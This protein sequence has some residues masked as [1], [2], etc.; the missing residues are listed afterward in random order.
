VSKKYVRNYWTIALIFVAIS[1]LGGA[2]I[3]GAAGQD[4]PEPQR[5]PL[6]EEERRRAVQRLIEQLQKQQGVNPRLV[7]GQPAPAAPA[8]GQPAAP[9]A[10]PAPSPS[11]SPVPSVVQRAPL[12]GGQVQLSYDNADLYEFINQIA[13]T[14]GLTPV[15][16]DPEVKG[17]VTIHSSAPMAKEDL[18][19]LFNLILKNNNA[20]LVKQGNIYQIVPISS[21]LKKGLDII[22]H[23][24]PADA[25]PDPQTTGAVSPVAPTVP[26]TPA[27]AVPQPGAQVVLSQPASQQSNR[28]ATHV[29][30]VE[31]V[32]VRDLIDPLKLFMTEGGII[33][34][35]DRLNM[36]IV[37]DYGDS[38][39][40]I[41]DVIRLLDSN[42][43]DPELVELAKI[44]NNAS[45]DVAED[46]KKIFGSGARESA[47]GVNFVS[48]DRLNSILI[49][50]S[51]K[52]A[53]TEARTWIERLDATTGRSV[54]TY[55]YTVE[56]STAA[57]IAQILSALFGSE[58]GVAGFTGTSE[59]GAAGPFGV[60]RTPQSGSTQ[61]G[62][63]VSGAGGVTGGTAAG[64]G[65]PFGAGSAQGGYQ[66]SGMFGGGSTFGGGGTGGGGFGG[67]GGAFGGGFIGG[68]QQL[69]PRLNPTGSVSSQVLR[70]GGFSGLQDSVRVV[71]DE[72]NNALI[73]QASAPD[74]FYITDVI[75]KLDVLPRQALID[76]RIFEVDL[77]DTFAFGISGALRP[78]GSG[79]DGEHLTTAAIDTETGALSAN[80]FA[81]IGS[82]RDILLRLDALRT[83][84]KV[85]ILEAP[86]V[87]ALDG[88]VARIVV[89]AE[90][91]YP[92]T[93]FIA[94][95]GGS[96][97]SVQYRDTGISLI[98]E[99]RISGSGTVTLNV[100]Q[101]VSSPGAATPTG[102]TFTKTSVATTLAVQDG[103]TVAIAGLIRDANSH[104]RSGVPFLSEIP[105][106]GSLFGTTTKTGNRTELLILITP[107]VIRNPESFQHM[108][109]ELKDSLRNVRKW[110]D[111]KQEEHV[112]DMEDARKDRVKEE[113]KQMKKTGPRK[114]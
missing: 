47:T 109:Q 12:A 104:S 77:T 97:T 27:P 6:N 18:L 19:P 59:R 48:L 31:F 70:G 9:G 55:V 107:H 102:P 45:A 30:R 15:V 112:E 105:L 69:G 67:G 46:L 93:S 29:I 72:I 25:K 16:I 38:V 13:D 80:T 110:A 3:S 4:Q 49:M 75:K 108:S 113:E 103:Q 86:S 21:G 17:S 79:A 37:T 89:G 64:T 10:P 22:E 51:S 87:L 53:L 73:I 11:P 50:A 95:A 8:P 111:K 58:G 96:T 24:P 106:I 5:Q 52:R 62:G 78:R 65:G 92:G 83:K 39:S 71:V 32:P 99:P 1:L 94:P 41:L 85:R 36:L 35:Y 33:M 56:N 98:V 44:K 23:L 74:Y 20:A 114:D 26:A 43:L 81:F 61:G 7:P 82:A 88:T 57:N 28:L 91:P 84:T 54:Q 40:K 42:Y 68:G 14:L 90:V 63:L 2:L 66:G 34:P 60:G 100:A 76:A 101:E